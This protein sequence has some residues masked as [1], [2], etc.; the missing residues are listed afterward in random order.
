[1]VVSAKT[2]SDASKIPASQFPPDPN[3][4]TSTI[5]TVAREINEAG[6]HALALQVDVRDP[7]QIND[8]VNEVVKRLGKVD[9]V[10]YNS[11]AIWWSAVETTPFKRF[12][13]MQQINPEGKEAIASTFQ[14]S[15]QTSN[16]P[17][18][19]RSVRHSTSS[20][21]SFQV[22]WMAG[23]YYRGITSHLQSF[24]P[25]KDSLRHGQSRDVRS[26]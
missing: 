1:M 18:W 8:L 5:N 16:V 26:Y 23:P 24:L 19:N 3:S 13:L 9:V 21:S 11:G 22:K 17:L 2:I 4:S 20:L 6:G 25:G 10:V 14:V 12:R 15:Y 7:D